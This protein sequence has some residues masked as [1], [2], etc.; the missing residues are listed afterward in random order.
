MRVPT[1]RAVDATGAVLVVS[2]GELRLDP[3]TREWVNVVGH[4]QARPNLPPTECPFCVGGLEA[5]D[6]YTVRAFT[7]RWPA[8]TP[9]E[10]VDLASAVASGSDPLPARGAAEVVLYS[11]QHDASLAT[12]GIDHVREVVDVWAERTE[13]L[14]SRSE[15]RYVLV[16][17]NRGPE[18]GATI[19]HPHGQIY[20]FPFVPPVP[21]RIA[22]VA[23]EHGDPVAEELRR[24]LVDRTR[25]VATAGAWTAY[26]PYASGY[27]YGLRLVPDRATDRLADL[28]ARERLDL[29]RLLADVT[30]RYDALF[31][32]CTDRPVPFPYLM[33][34]HQAPDPRPPYWFRLHVQFAPPWR[35]AEVERFVA[36]G[37]L[38]S[39]TLSNPVVPEEA[40]AELRDAS[41]TT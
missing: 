20:A 32:D 28:D 12:L 39:G 37:E 19:H 21:Q 2:G 16:F 8:M 5:P 6:S 1:S 40:A 9:G 27:P 26:V 34:I 35:A 23:A 36:S 17:E 13:T 22:D 24:E 30:G 15:I 14:L 11:P 38:G 41:P 10:P 4:R 7:N 33:W 29:A 31:P 25:I 18:V 3:L